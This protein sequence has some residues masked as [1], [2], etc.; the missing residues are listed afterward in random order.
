MFNMIRRILFISQYLNRAGTE[1]FMMNVFRGIDHS[2]FQIDFLLYSWNE[3]DYSREV[4]A[5]GCHVWRVPCRKESPLEWYRSVYKFFKEHSKDYVAI[6]YCGN[7]LT[8]IFPI[9]MA[10]HFRVPIR[11]IHSHNSSSKGFHNRL[12]HVLQRGIAKRL[13]TYHFAC[14]SLAAKWF[15]G[16]SPAVIIRNGIDTKR[17]AFSEAVR[18]VVREDNGIA[19]STTVIGHV[20]RFSEEKN[21]AFLLDIFAEYLKSRPDTLLLLVGIGTQMDDMKAKAE[22]LGIFRKT[23]FLGERSDVNRLMQAMDMFLMPST[24]E[25]QPFVL[26]EAQCAGLPCLVSDVINDDICLTA[27]VRKYSL[28]QSAADWAKQIADVLGSYQRRDE[29]QTI[30]DKGY[31]M[32]GTIKYLEDVY[33]GSS[34][35]HQI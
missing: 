23:Q 1:A 10:Y 29:S 9:V 18:H 4:E 34:P 14:S 27:N 32:L 5:A 7:G 33:D 2:R 13:T 25:G 21:H 12:L 28:K 35:N 3:T 30:Q 16:S 24:F 26:I 20:G 8:A 6:H 17:F 19:P 15:F 31:S 11:I 22:R